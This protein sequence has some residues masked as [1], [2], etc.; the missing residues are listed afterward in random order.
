MAAGRSECRRTSS[1]AILASLPCQRSGPEEQA[2]AQ[3][4]PEQ[5]WKSALEDACKE[6]LR[7]IARCSAAPAEG[8]SISVEDIVRKV[9]Q[10]S[11]EQA[12]EKGLTLGQI[13]A[14]GERDADPAPAP[15][16]EDVEATRW[17][18]WRRRR[19]G[20]SAS[21]DAGRQPEGVPKTRTAESW[22]STAT[23]AT[24]E[25][26]ASTR[27]STPSDD[28]GFAEES[29]DASEAICEERT[30]LQPRSQQIS[31]GS[32]LPSG[33]LDSEAMIAHHGLTV[34]TRGAEPLVMDWHDRP[35][36][37]LLVAK[38]RDSIVAENAQD[39]AAWLASQGMIVVLEPHVH[40]QLQAMI[41]DARTFSSAD[42]LERSIDLVITVGGDGTLTWA[43]SLFKGAMPPV[44]SFAAG[45]LGFLTP[46][47]LDGWVRT[48]TELLDVHV[49]RL[50]AVPS[51]VCRSR[52]RVCVHRRGRT[53]DELIELQ[54]L[55]EVLVHRG[56]SGALA[57][58]DV[59]VDGDRI[60][61]VQGDGLIL[62]TPT[63]ST[64]YSLAAGGSMVHPGVPAILLTPVS[65]HS[66]SFRPALLPESSIVAVRIPLTA[67]CGAALSVD[68]KDIC[69]LGVGDSVEVAV[70][71]HPVPTICHTS[72]TSDWFA[73]VN[74]ALQWNGRAEQKC[75]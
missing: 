74:Q 34:A 17:T 44:L 13:G 29:E 59:S 39:I 2:A 63:G 33:L 40:S 32:V 49:H 58:L 6:A 36:A 64:A 35:R 19:Q 11:L 8:G 54:C 67:R 57:K 22:A 46:F 14:R 21:Q 50:R 66:L 62:A 10:R 18:L 16:L 65:P 75:C 70:S 52:F 72:E 61:L 41:P 1:P 15:L 3:S 38:P 9:A 7:E 47:S 28:S 25:S 30:P 31:P 51:L 26:W 12:A 27:A 37:V 60:T 20:G 56:N 4:G 45:S 55:N 43:V 71:P 24:T 48:L 53:R 5:A 68:G 69:Q 73:S 42:R 23:T